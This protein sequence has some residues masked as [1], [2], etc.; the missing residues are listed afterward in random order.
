[1]LPPSH[2]PAYLHLCS[3][4]H[5]P[6]ITI[7]TGL[8]LY[9]GAHPL[10]LHQHI[11]PAIIPLFKHYQF[12]LFTGSL[13]FSIKWAVIFSPISKQFLPEPW[14]SFTIC[15]YFYVPCIAKLLIELP[16]Y[17]VTASSPP[18]PEPTPSCF[19]PHQA[20][21]TAVSQLTS[22]MTSMSP[23]G[24]AL[25]NSSA[26]LLPLD[27]PPTAG[28]SFSRAQTS[29]SLQS[30]LTPRSSLMISNTIQMPMN[31]KFISSGSTSFLNSGFT[32]PIA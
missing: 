9:P 2:L 4:T 14:T 30:A 20:T 31:S 18:S 6:P 19:C 11:S 27:T 13:G 16:I 25:L 24:L 22:G 10:S 5:L 28:S 32:Y 15:C 7:P 29:N 3:D 12:F 1:M 23:D 8:G 17:I 21:E 26:W